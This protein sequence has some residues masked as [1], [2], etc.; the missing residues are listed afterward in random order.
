MAHKYWGS[1][2][3]KT[4]QNNQLTKEAHRQIQLERIKAATLEKILQEKLRQKA[5]EQS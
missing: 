3:D 4:Y 1:S 2:S 5:K